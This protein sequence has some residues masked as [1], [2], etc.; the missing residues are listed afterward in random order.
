MPADDLPLAS[1]FPKATHEMWL[2]LVDKVLNGAPFD[3][4]LI[5][6]TYDGIALQPLYTQADWKADGENLPA[7]ILKIM[8]RTGKAVDDAETSR[9]YRRL[10]V[11]AA[12]HLVFAQ[13]KGKP[14]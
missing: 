13:A 1:E 9:T 6:R 2:K 4:K 7:A 3:K 14:R 5:S 8:Q 10:D 11:Q 12:L